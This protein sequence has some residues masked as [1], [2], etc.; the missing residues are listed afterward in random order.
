MGLWCVST[1]KAAL[2]FKRIAG[3][4]AEGNAFRPGLWDEW[5]Y[6]FA[7]SFQVSNL[8]GGE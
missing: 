6:F 8:S 5:R 2:I 7:F 3:G 4:T 1:E